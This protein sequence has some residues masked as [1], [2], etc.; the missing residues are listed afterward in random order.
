M[1]ERK[2]KAVNCGTRRHPIPVTA[3]GYDPWK[4]KPKAHQGVAVEMKLPTCDVNATEKNPGGLKFEQHLQFSTTEWRRVHRQRNL[5]ESANRSL[6]R[7]QLESLADPDL[8]HV[9]VNT[10]T[11]V[12]PCTPLLCDTRLRCSGGLWTLRIPSGLAGPEASGP[13][14]SDII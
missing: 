2:G 3:P 11:Y 12:L 7:S 13:S 10:F 1:L 5:V 4:L 14:R 6:K 8:R 9:R